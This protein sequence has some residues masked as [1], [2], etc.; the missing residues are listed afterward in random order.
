MDAGGIR[1]VTDEEVA[2]YRDHGWVKM[3]QLISPELVELMLDR[4]KGYMGPNADLDFVSSDLDAPNPYWRDY[5]NVV[6]KDSCFRS[7]GLNPQM[8]V[9]AQRLM[10]RNVD[11]L[12]SSNLLAVKIGTK[13]SSSLSPS[14]QPTLFHQYGAGLPYDRGG[15]VAFWVALDHIIPEMGTVRFVDRSH[16]LGALGNM[17]DQSGNVK[18][19]LFNV[20]P[21]LGDMKLTEPLEFQPGDVSAHTMYTVHGAAANDTDTPR[22]ALIISYIPSDTVFTGARPCS[23]GTR[24]KIEKAGLVVG[25]PF[26]GPMYPRV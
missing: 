17:R 4:A 20:Y 21:Q 2:H 6:E 15:W 5:H 8:G 26:G 25:E 12:L 7:V 16:H 11:V 10:G 23:Q 9:N 19:E 13:Q 14:S 24:K 18:D 3:D 1:A 22:W